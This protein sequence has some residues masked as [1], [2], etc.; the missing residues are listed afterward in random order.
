MDIQKH[1]HRM[2]PGED[3]FTL[4][5]LYYGDYS[6]WTIIYHAN[7]D[8]L[9]DNPES[10]KQGMT[11]YVPLVETSDENIKMPAAIPAS[12]FTNSEDPLIQFA[13][14]RYGDQSVAFD[15]REASGL[16]DDQVAG[17]GDELKLPARG[18]PKNLKLAEF[19]RG[20]FRR[21]WAPGR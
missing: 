16:T 13:R 5:E 14:E 17:E 3:I 12:S 2:A 20:K 11:I 4:A 19:W 10:A 7:L 18:N 9:G 8:A 21:R 1:P 15:I 6:A